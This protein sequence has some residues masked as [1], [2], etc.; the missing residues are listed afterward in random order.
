MESRLFRLFLTGTYTTLFGLLVIISSNSQAADPLEKK[1]EQI[2]LPELERREIKQATVDADDFEIGG[3]AGVLSI[4][5]FGVNAVYGARL[6]YHVTEDIFAEISAG[7]SKASETSFEV[8]SGGLQ[9][10]TEDERKLTYYNIS[11]GYNLF[12]G[13]SFFGKRA[14]NSDLYLI[15]GVGNTNFANSDHFTWNVG[16]GYRFIPRDWFTIHVDVRDHIFNSDILGADKQTHNLELTAGF[17][18]FF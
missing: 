7:Q 6:A 14:F 3:F 5:D 18:F 13:E 2:I 1:T 11:L 16:V 12:A 8:L 17:T 9:L 10:L 15:A 4:E